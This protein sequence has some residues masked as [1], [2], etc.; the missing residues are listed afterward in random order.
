MSIHLEQQGF[1][2]LRSFQ[3]LHSNAARFTVRSRNFCAS[4]CCSMKCWKRSIV[5]SEMKR[6]V[7][8]TRKSCEPPCRS[9]NMTPFPDRTDWERPEAGEH[10]PLFQGAYTALLVE[11]SRRLWWGSGAGIVGS[12]RWLH[13]LSSDPWHSHGDQH[14]PDEAV[15]TF[16][17]QC[18]QS[19]IDHWIA[20]P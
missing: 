5:E 9:S 2:S 6:R 15:D 3:K 18:L 12:T 17:L 13:H 20:L 19:S 1:S 14:E 11:P 16:Q 8:D 7:L 4:P 10:E